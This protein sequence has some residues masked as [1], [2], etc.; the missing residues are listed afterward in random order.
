MD[1]CGGIRALARW[2]VG[3]GSGWL[4]VGIELGEGVCVVCCLAWL[5]QATATGQDIYFFAWNLRTQIINNQN[6][7]F[8]IFDFKSKSCKKPYKISFLAYLIAF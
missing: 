5:D 6:V 7:F 4:E 8:F 1:G 2:E 3:G